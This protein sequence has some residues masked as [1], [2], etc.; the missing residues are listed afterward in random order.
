MW[1]PLWTSWSRS[2]TASTRLSPKG[3][4]ERQSWKDRH[5]SSAALLMEKPA[6]HLRN[7]K[8]ALPD[9]CNIRQGKRDQNIRKI[10][11]YP[12]LYRRPGRKARRKLWIFT[13]RSARSSSSFWT[14]CWGMWSSFMSTRPPLWPAWTARR[15]GTWPRSG[16]MRP[17]T[18][19]RSRGCWP[20][21]RAMARMTLGLWKERRGWDVGKSRSLL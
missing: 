6:V 3:G 15:P 19:R 9:G 8:N 17:R 12:P 1:H 7:R 16:W 11:L 21:A 2:G 18:R 4:G 5:P 20:T 13:S 14:D 10:S